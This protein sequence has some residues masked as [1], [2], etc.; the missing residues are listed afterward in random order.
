MQASNSRT[1]QQAPNWWGTTRKWLGRVSPRGP[2]EP[3]IG[4]ALGGGFARGIAHVGVLRVF[5]QHRIP[6]HAIS[7][8][9]AG[10]MVAAA[11]ASGSNAAEI[12]VI[13]R[14]MK[15]RDV[16]RWTISRL[17]LAGSDRMISFL[18]R[19]L[20]V[21][22]FEYMRIPLSVVAT[23][24]C[25]GK[26]VI[27][28]GSGDVVTPIRASCSFPGLFMPLRYQNRYLVDG[29]VGMEVP[30]EPLRQMGA[31]HVIS[32]S[33]P[34]AREAVDP[35]SMFSVVDRC[36]QTMSIRLENEW[37]RH[38]DVVLEPDV[39]EI[40]WDSF[41][42]AHQLIE[43]GERAALAALPTIQKWLAPPEPRK[44]VAGLR[45]AVPQPL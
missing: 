13:G 23:D 33:I 43:A 30:A 17:G 35:T 24:L 40:A 10:A 1:L 44:S 3:R 8:V 7:G 19:L 15:F 4:L 12:E 42:S 25:T 16:A 26:P 38:S 45:Q 29:F 20:K 39:A 22:R 18:A 37:R 41:T 5:E 2:R 21:D 28:N 36:F 34:N 31:T 6:V 14:S 32:V 9:S 11:F 27:F